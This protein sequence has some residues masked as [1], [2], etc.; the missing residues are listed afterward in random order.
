MPNMG[1]SDL[2]Q[3]ASQRNAGI[4][5]AWQTAVQSVLQ[6]RLANAQNELS[7]RG[8]DIREAEAAQRSRLGNESLN[9]QR[10]RNAATREYQ[11]KSLEQGE[12]RLDLIKNPPKN[13]WDKTYESIKENY[14]SDSPEMRAFLA[15]IKPTTPKPPDRKFDQVMRDLRINYKRDLNGINQQY[16]TLRQR[17]NKGMDTNLTPFTGSVNT[18]DLVKELNDLE[19]KAISRLKD[20]YKNKATEY[21][22]FFRVPVPNDKD[23]PWYVEPAETPK[24]GARGGGGRAVQYALED[25]TIITVNQ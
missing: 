24:S 10:E 22:R 23:Y 3:Y 9:L 5:D 1:G 16:D 6:Q 8:L 20:T 15:N 12:K 14:G 13:T 18:A 2:A 4:L 17:A 25:G 7:S 21:S 11:D 19:Q